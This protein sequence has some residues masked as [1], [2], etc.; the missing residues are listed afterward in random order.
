[1]NMPVVFNDSLQLRA[2][3]VRFR[4][5]GNPFEFLNS[6][7]ITPVKEKIYRGSNIVDVA[8]ELNIPIT[9]LLKWIDENGYDEEISAASTLSAEGYVS[10]G[11]KMLHA[12]TNK[13]ELDKAKAMIEHGRFMASKKDKKT[14]GNAIDPNQGAPSVTYIFQVGATPATVIEAQ[15]ARQ[16]KQAID[17]EFVKVVPAQIEV[18][19]FDL[20]AVPLHLKTTGVKVDE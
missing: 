4:G 1:M 10:K 13:F 2:K 3:Q 18:D 19:P 16:N 8:E 14:Y 6:I 5:I 17:A 12:A 7:G 9:Y 15:T 20:G 11:E